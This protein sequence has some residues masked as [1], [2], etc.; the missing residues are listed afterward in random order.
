MWL[1]TGLQN[2]PLDEVYIVVY[3]D[4][5]LYSVREDGVI[6]KLAAYVCIQ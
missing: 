4:A 2:R 1:R 6:R 5:I 3:F